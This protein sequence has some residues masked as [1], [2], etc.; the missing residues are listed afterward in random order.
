M[1]N[2]ERWR[3]SHQI[4][5]LFFR[6]YIK[7][8]VISI[9]FQHYLKRILKVDYFFVLCSNTILPMIISP[10]TRAG[11]GSNSEIIRRNRI[12]RNESLSLV[13]GRSLDIY[14]LMWFMVIICGWQ[15]V[16]GPF[17]R[18]YYVL[19]SFFV[20]WILV[21]SSFLFYTTNISVIMQL[22]INQCTIL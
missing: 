13:V 7:Q 20:V 12:L 21:E 6:L 1:K 15:R 3:T 5:D 2:K 19:S 16:V 14:S 17:I 11:K 22:S 4:V 8:I 9:I 10:L 18:Q